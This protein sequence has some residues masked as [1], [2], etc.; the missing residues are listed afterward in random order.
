MALEK[1]RIFQIVVELLCLAVFAVQ[2][3]SVV[4]KFLGHATLDSTESID[5]TEL[6]LP[7][8]TICPGQAWKERK[9]MATYQAFM[10][11]SFRLH[12]I[13]DNETLEQ[14]EQNNFDLKPIFSYR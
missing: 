5:E 2:I 4:R 12:E 10:D 14:F 13:F 11:N 6:Q 3:S 7:S 1:I 8:V 9:V